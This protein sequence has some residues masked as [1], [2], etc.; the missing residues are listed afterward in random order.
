M[1]LAMIDSGMEYLICD[2]LLGVATGNWRREE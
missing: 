2:G 1:A